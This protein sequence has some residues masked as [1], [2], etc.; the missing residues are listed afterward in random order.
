M[1]KNRPD[2]HKLQQ[3]EI[4]DLL[5]LSS[6]QVH[7]LVQ[8][9]APGVS[10]G[11]G[12]KVFDGPVFVRW[13]WERKMDEAVKAASPPGEWDAQ[14]RLHSARAEMTELDLAERR[15]TLLSADYVAEQLERS[16]T[17]V[18]DAILTLQGRAQRFVGLKSPAESKAALRDLEAELLRRLSSVGSSATLDS[19]AKVA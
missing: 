12:K 2:L 10:S 1:A 3:S 11:E 14:A 13:Y 4:A 8:Q 18:K 7:N 5:S 16:L 6:R 15:R 17:A 9:G 19:E